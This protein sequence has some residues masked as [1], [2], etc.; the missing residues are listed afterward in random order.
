MAFA[1]VP[2]ES[3][4]QINKAGASLV[5]NPNDKVALD[6]ANRW[7]ACHAYPINTFNATLRIKSK[8]FNES[9]IVAQ[10][11]KRMPTI[12]D[13]LKR[14]PS[15]KLARMQDIGGLR[16]VLTSTKCVYEL[17]SSYKDTRFRHELVNE[18]DYI[19]EPR[20]EDGYRSIHLIF[21]YKGANSIANKYDGLLLELQIRTKLQ[22]IWAT[23]VETMGTFLGQ[24][25]KARL[26]DKEWQDFFALVSSAFAISERMPVLPRH[27]ELS[28]EDIYRAIQKANEELGVLERIKGYAVAVEVI[29]NRPDSSRRGHSYHLVVLN[30]DARS[31]QVKSYKKGAVKQALE[32]YSNIENRALNGEKIEAVLV[33]AGGPLAVLRQAYPN[34]FLDIKDFV[35]KI[36]DIVRKAKNL[37]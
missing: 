9:V 35:G 2:R 33:S 30:S 36:E 16:A 14:Y 19:K 28:K 15:M 29:S 20:D 11:L 13:K 4:E 8:A 10:R 24:A 7:R 25:L 34:F 3:K 37:K 18:K 17:A 12:V 1:P 21:K 32:D 27:R 22:H 5:S 23:A 31:V 6:L 26:G